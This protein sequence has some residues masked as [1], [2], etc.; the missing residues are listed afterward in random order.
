MTFDQAINGRSL[1][2]TQQEA[3]VGGPGRADFSWDW[4]S[5]SMANATHHTIPKEILTR[6]QEAALEIL[7]ERADA[8]FDHAGE[9][10]PIKPRFN[11]LLVAPTGSGKTSLVRKL[12]ARMGAGIFVVSCSEWNPWSAR[13][14]P[15]T[16]KLL[17]EKI[18]ENERVILLF[19]EVDKWTSTTDDPW[20][21]YVSAELWA[22]L[23]RRLPVEA[24]CKERDLGK[25]YI[26]T[27][28]ERIREDV[29]F[30]GAGTFEDV[31]ATAG[32]PT[33]GFSGNS[34]EFSDEDIHALIKKRQCVSPE[35]LSRFS[36]EPIVLRYPDLEETADLLRR[37]G[38]SE[39]IDRSNMLI[40]PESIDWSG[41]GMRALEQLAADLII[42]QRK[43]ERQFKEYLEE[44]ERRE[45]EERKDLPF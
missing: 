35:L 44:Q 20:V 7:C 39:M 42:E 23:D 27:L 40:D 9:E 25:E 30:V 14:Q 32:K 2:F 22:T 19:D 43:E 3:L 11:S 10:L 45:D 13:Q 36:I 12:A 1:Q 24:F 21:R 29:Y 31:F 6:S 37:M 4:L 18:L 16:L 17:L 15:S 34:G 5:S 8:Y 38:L 41:A 28:N 26:D 33:C